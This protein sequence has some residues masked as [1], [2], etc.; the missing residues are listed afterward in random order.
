MTIVF[1]VLPR[2]ELF[3]SQVARD[4]YANAPE[5][6]IKHAVGVLRKALEPKSQV[7]SFA[8]EVK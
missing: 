8:L 4:L 3:Q 6:G 5:P 2:S 1:A 7:L